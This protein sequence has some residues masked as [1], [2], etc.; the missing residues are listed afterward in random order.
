MIGKSQF[1]DIMK[2]SEHIFV[3]YGY[4]CTF[5]FVFASHAHPTMLSAHVD[6]VTSSF[7]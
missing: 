6:V 3:L 2:Y 4:F 7:N 5:V 1:I